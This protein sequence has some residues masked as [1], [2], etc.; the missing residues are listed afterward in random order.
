MRPGEIDTAQVEALVEMNPSGQ[1]PPSGVL[2]SVGTHYQ[3]NGAMAV[4]LRLD[5]PRPELTSTSRRSRRH[6]RNLYAIGHGYPCHSK[7][8]DQDGRLVELPQTAVNFPGVRAGEIF[9][10]PA[11]P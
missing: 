11:F 7:D 5:D 3:A 1:L 6:G 9:S 4:V 8:H 10:R 2:Q